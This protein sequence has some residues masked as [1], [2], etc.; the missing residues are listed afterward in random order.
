MSLTDR[1]IR[2][3]SPSDKAQRYY[4]ERGLY[5]EVAP[6]GGKWW[7][8]KYRFAGKEKRLSLGV[9]PEVGLKDASIKCAE[10]RAILHEGIAPL[11]KN[12]TLLP[13]TVTPGW[14][15]FRCTWWVTFA[16]RLTGAT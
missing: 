1:E 10:A 7:R 4:D 6:S 3:I 13:Q 14:V 5:R 2:N 12:S 9:Y 15:T 8:Y 16:C 11:G